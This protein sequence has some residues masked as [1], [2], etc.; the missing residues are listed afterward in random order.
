VTAELA[1]RQQLADFAPLAE[2]AAAIDNTSV[3]RFRGTVDTIAGFVRLPYDVL[4]GRTIAAEAVGQFDVTVSVTD[5]LAWLDEDGPIPARRDA[6]WL[7]PL[8]PER[9]WQRVESV[10]DSEIRGLI[11]SGAALAQDASSKA[12][13]EAL[14]SSVVLTATSADRAVAV[15]LGP[16]SAL[17]RMG[18]L[19]RG[20]QA[21]VDVVPGWIRIAAPYGSTFVT[22]GVSPLGMLNLGPF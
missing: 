15:P 8:P 6:H 5:L 4:A 20:A 14:L 11:R 16:L 2:R 17:T 3:I 12:G 13:Q 1:T 7:S 9:G 21:A 18:F 19:P 10:P 22:T